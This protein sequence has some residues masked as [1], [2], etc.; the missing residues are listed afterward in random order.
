MLTLVANLEGKGRLFIGN[1]CQLACWNNQLLRVPIYRLATFSP[2]NDLKVVYLFGFVPL[3]KFNDKLISLQ[4]KWR[5]KEIRHV[6]MACQF[7][8]G[9]QTCYA[10][11][12]YHAFVAGASYW[13]SI[14]YDLAKIVN[15]KDLRSLSGK[16]SGK[17]SA[18]LKKYKDQI[19]TKVF[20]FN[21][22]L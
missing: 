16:K 14:H 10:I 4:V 6:D 2:T 21:S 20:I 11:T 9:F 17:N 15:C 19:P 8:G 3:Y 12:M 13:Q 1:C 5:I 18:P 22:S 7:N